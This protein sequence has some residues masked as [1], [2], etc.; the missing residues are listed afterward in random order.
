VSAAGYKPPDTTTRRLELTVKLG[1]P[2]G[3]SYCP[4]QLLAQ[5]TVSHSIRLLTAG[6]LDRIIDNCT[7]DQH[8]LEVHFSGFCEPFAH[9][10]ILGLMGACEAR[11][12]VERIVMYSTG[13]GATPAD[14][15]AMGS[16]EKLRGKVFWHVRPGAAIVDLIP[17]IAEHLPNSEFSMVGSNCSRT[18]RRRVEEALAVAKAAGVSEATGLNLKKSRQGTRAGNVTLQETGQ[19]PETIARH[20]VCCDRV[21]ESSMPVVL[22]SGATIACCMDYGGELA[23]GNLL[24]DRWEK[25]DFARILD[26]QQH[27]NTDCICFRG[28][29]FAKPA[30]PAA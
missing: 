14:I 22:P 11:A 1:C 19:P 25:L 12:N 5:A 17:A 7:D 30:K 8:N 20:P 24:I 28:C 10:D 3:C 27:P 26:L 18:D 15:K 2:V 6:N 16:L 13:I 21:G 29:R 23:I 9:P 4:Q